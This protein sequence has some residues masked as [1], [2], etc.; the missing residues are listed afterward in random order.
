MA[1]IL[2]KNIEW[3]AIDGELC[4]VLTFTPFAKIEADQVTSE[5]WTAP[6]ALLELETAKLPPNTTGAVTH[7]DDFKRLWAAF[8]E[9][10]VGADEEVIVAWS[11]SHLR[12]F[13]AKLLSPFLG[14]LNVMICRRGAYEL[15][16]DPSYQPNLT[17]EARW[18]AE[19]PILQWQAQLP[20]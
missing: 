15:L 2:R 9:R 1:V 4:K 19:K 10:G 12:G 7:R 14:R 16:T 20:W 13:V 6:Y 5:N 18:L 3:A 8:V 11:T 17:G